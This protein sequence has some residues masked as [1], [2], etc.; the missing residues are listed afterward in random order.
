MA[1]KQFISVTPDVSAVQAAL[2]GTSRSLENIQRRV[3]GTIA[4]GARKKINAA[5]RGS[6]KRRTGELLK[7]YRY[8]LKKDASAASVY[9]KKASKKSKI[10]P[11]VYALNYGIEGTGHRARGFVQRGEQY[12]SGAEYEKDVNKYVQNELDK[13][14]GD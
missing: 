7:S 5:I 3:L 2:E 6:T 1:T 12:A 4:A 10:F 14:W 11:K 13:Y 8:K 9:P